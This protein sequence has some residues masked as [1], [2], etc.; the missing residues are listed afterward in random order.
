MPEEAR[1]GTETLAYSHRLNA[2]SS[3]RNYEEDLRSVAKP[4]LVVAGTADEALIPE[5]LEP[6]I[7]QHVKARVELLQDVTHMGVVVGPE[8]RS[9]IKEWLADPYSEFTP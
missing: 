5:E 2:S 1:D 9:V 8:I 4:L 7:T 3:P 6:T